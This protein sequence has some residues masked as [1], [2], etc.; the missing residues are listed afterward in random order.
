MAQVS[1]RV[2]IVGGGEV[3]GLLAHVLARRNVAP[4]IC[5]IDDNARAAQGKAL[6]MSQA[7]PVEGFASNVSGSADLTT[8]A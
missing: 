2:A 5:L 1:A 4:E 7:A 3:G 8:I 6:D